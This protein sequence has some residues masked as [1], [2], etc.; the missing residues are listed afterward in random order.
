M[1]CVVVCAAIPEEIG[2]ICRHF[3]V[4]VP[5]PQNPISTCML[6]EH[7]LALAVSGVGRLRMEALLEPLDPQLRY[8][9]L[10]I[11]LAGG[12]SPQLEVGNGIIGHTIV[13]ANR[14]VVHTHP[15]IFLRDTDEDAMLLCLDEILATPAR[16]RVFH[17]HTGAMAVDMESIAVA[18]HANARR[19]PFAWIK[20]I[21]DGWDESLPCELMDCTDEHG[22][23]SVKK[24]LF[25]LAKKPQYLPTMIKMGL[26]TRRVSKLLSDAVV[27]V[28]EKL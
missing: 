25:F 11:G 2:G 23:P 17:E 1:D 14:N 10:S 4:P 28:L 24:S 6:T 8:G 7:K 18:R 20:V 27:Q 9:W 16:K 22:Y 12:L 3:G 13:C 21:S 15:P 5:S 19:E 26:R